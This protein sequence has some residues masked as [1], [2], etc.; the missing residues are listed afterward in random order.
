MSRGERAINRVSILENASDVN[1]HRLAAQTDAAEL[2][3]ARARFADLSDE[4]A[5]AFV[6]R[7]WLRSQNKLPQDTGRKHPQLGV[8]KPVGQPTLGHTWSAGRPLIWLLGRSR[9]WSRRTRCDC[10]GTRRFPR[11]PWMPVSIPDRSIPGRGW[12]AHRVHTSAATWTT[13]AISG[14]QTRWCV[15]GSGQSAPCRLR[16]RRRRYG[17]APST[18]RP[19]VFCCLVSDCFAMRR[20][21]EAD[22]RAV[23]RCVCAI[24]VLTIG[25]V[26]RSG[27]GLLHRPRPSW[28]GSPVGGIRRIGGLRR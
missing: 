27:V 26:A 7:P 14:Y 25:V 15:I 24:L 16:S 9:L 19:V 5:I 28:T 13:A 6:L 2:D 20:Q 17:A 18:D 3:D 8:V 23:W 11:S 10:R 1:L 21:A 22:R 12:R 4:D